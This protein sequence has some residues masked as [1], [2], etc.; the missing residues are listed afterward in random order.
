MMKTL[1]DVCELLVGT[2]QQLLSVNPQ[3]SEAKKE[4]SEVKGELFNVNDRM[5]VLERTV[6]ATLA[7]SRGDAGQRVADVFELLEPILLQLDMRTLLL[8]QRDT[9]RFRAVVK[10]SDLIQQALFLKPAPKSLLPDG[11]P[12]PP[13]LNPLLTDAIN[14]RHIPVSFNYNYDGSDGIS[15][16]SPMVLAADSELAANGAALAPGACE[17]VKDTER[18]EY[19]VRMRFDIMPGDFRPAEV[20]FTPGKYVNRPSCLRMYVTQP[21]AKVSFNWF[22]VRHT[23]R[24]WKALPSGPL[25]EVLP[26]KQKTVMGTSVTSKRRVNVRTR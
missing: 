10:G 21:P 25:A 18:G 7:P 17:V 6:T 15:L 23:H 11:T 5:V 3:L 26:L 9:R 4:L 24:Q 16:D 12:A 20:C 14:Y 19:I 2:N 13:V 8:A 22:P 1:D